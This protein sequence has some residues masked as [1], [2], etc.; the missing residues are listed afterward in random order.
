MTAYV[1]LVE[2]QIQL[3]PKALGN[4]DPLGGRFTGRFTGGRFTGQYYK[5]KVTKQTTILQYITNR[6]MYTP[7]SYVNIVNFY[8]T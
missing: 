7:D 6:P 1:L 2:T 4:C 8:I 5:N 3:Q